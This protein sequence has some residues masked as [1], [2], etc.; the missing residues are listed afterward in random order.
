MILMVKIG[1]NSE[2]W[3]IKRLWWRMLVNYSERFLEN[4]YTCWDLGGKNVDFKKNNGQKI[5]DNK[6]EIETRLR[7]ETLLKYYT[8]CS[9][10]CDAN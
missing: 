9:Q 3:L 8:T 5:R 4:T 10:P 6:C 7:L 1:N 2:E